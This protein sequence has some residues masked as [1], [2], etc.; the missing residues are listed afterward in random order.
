MLSDK[1]VREC[2]RYRYLAHGQ[3]NQPNSTNKHNLQGRTTL[4]DSLQGAKMHRYHRSP[5]TQ[6]SRRESLCRRSSVLVDLRARHPHLLMPTVLRALITSRRVARTRMPIL[7][8]P[9]SSIKARHRSLHRG[10]ISARLRRGRSHMYIR[11]LRI[12]H[13]GLRNMSG[14][15]QAD[16]QLR[17]LPLKRSQ[18]SHTVHT[19]PSHNHRLSHGNKF[20]IASGN[21][22]SLP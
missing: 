11:F 9:T 15:H 22:R 4:T 12:R 18:S 13:K 19:T 17:S 2:S 5:R 16:M 14:S 3:G 6:R 7:P 10:L 20:N 8:V 21:K 1:G